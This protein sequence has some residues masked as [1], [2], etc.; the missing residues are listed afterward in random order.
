[1]GTPDGSLGAESVQAAHVLAA[2]LEAALN[3]LEGQRRLAAREEEL[4]T[5]TE[6]AERLDRIAR[7][8]QRVEAAITEASSS[9]DVEQAVCE[10]LAETG[11]Y[12]LAWI[13]GVDAGSDRFVPRAIVGTTARYVE[14]MDLTTAGETVDPHPAVDAWTTDQLEVE[15]SL[16][17]DGPADD[18]RRIGLSEGYQSLCAVPL[19][20]D[21]VTRGV[22]TVG[23]ESPNEFGKRERDVLSQLGATIANALAAIERRRAL[24]S[25]ETVELSSAVLARHSRSH[26]RQPTRTVASDSNG[27]LP[28]RRGPRPSTSVSK[29]MSR[30][31][32][33]RSPSSASPG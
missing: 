11:P 4:Q 17:G 9:A 7:L 33:S 30:P 25:D 10:R 12:D 15:D 3:H 18:W 13:G 27:R 23:S 22:L 31:T 5:Q 21:D 1:M 24:E 8:T 32:R 20:Y 19:T 16:V 6:R 28:G 14:S 26:R 2:T 29:A